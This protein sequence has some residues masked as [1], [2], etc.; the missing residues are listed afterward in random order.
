MDNKR[1]NGLDGLRGILAVLIVAGHACVPG[2]AWQGRV[3]VFFVISG[4]LITGILA[5]EMDKSGT[6][7]LIRFWT[8]RAVKLLPP[9]F[10]LCLAVLVVWPQYRDAIW[11]A[12][13]LSTDYHLS[14][15]TTQ[16]GPLV[17][18]WS[19]AVEEH[20]YL[21]W[22]F[23]LLA[24]RYVRRAAWLPI[25]LTLFVAATIWRDVSYE[26]FGIAATYY[27]FD[28]RLGGLLAGSILA[29]AGKDR[30]WLVAVLL[31][32]ATVA[33]LALAIGVPTTYALGTPAAHALA[34][35][36]IAALQD[37]DIA[38]L[39]NRVMVW[40]GRRSYGVYLFHFP[41]VCWFNTYYG[42][43]WRV[44]FI[45]GLLGSLAVAALYTAAESR[46]VR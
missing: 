34:L 17:H 27:R 4:F 15:S 35:C 16:D 41:I 8:R 19:L 33:A 3:D 22:P 7:D 5:K 36:L 42:F 9:L 23:V 21:V 29:I 2:L 26:Q 6:I 12:A 45:G 39:S 43:D 46:L 44:S 14:F 11:A 37:R 20:F 10:I 13:T 25:L 18:T 31:L 32:A 24:L 28:P 40:V 38:A 1:I 30:R